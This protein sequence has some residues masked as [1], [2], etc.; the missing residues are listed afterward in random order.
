[1][2]EM[3]FN[4]THYVEAGIVSPETHQKLQAVKAAAFPRNRMERA[5]EFSG[6][7]LCQVCG[8]RMHGHQS[9]GKDRVACDHRG[10]NFYVHADRIRGPWLSM[11]RGIPRSQIAAWADLQE[12]GA[13][14]RSLNRRLAALDEEEAR[15]KKRR[16]AAFEL[17][18]DENAGIAR[19][20][21]LILSDVDADEVGLH[22]QRQAVLSQM[23][24]S[25][26]AK[27]T[28]EQVE[29]ALE[30][31]EG[32]YMGAG[33]ESRNAMNRALCAMI[34]SHPVLKR[35]GSG[36]RWA[37]VEVEW[38][39]FTRIAEYREPSPSGSLSSPRSPRLHSP[40]RP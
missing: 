33:I 32:I 37:K 20:A 14:E 24:T 25:G 31:F 3:I 9:K 8:T 39:E 11:L 1:M 13:D 27:Y 30:Q 5:H 34:G 38:P 22:A 35:T 40:Q 6:V 15:I 18:T 28:V 16:N 17:V 36:G 4:R 21:R 23:A 19:Q 7:F 26:K 2:N 12:G 10:H 29:S